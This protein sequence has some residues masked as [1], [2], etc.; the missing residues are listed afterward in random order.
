LGFS[1]PGTPLQPIPLCRCVFSTSHIHRLVIFQSSSESTQ[2]HPLGLLPSFQWRDYTWTIPPGQQ[3][4]STSAPVWLH[5]SAQAHLKSSYLFHPV[6][7]VRYSE[8]Q[9]PEGKNKKEVQ[10]LH[11]N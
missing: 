6:S 8:S 5:S 2:P 11:R 7:I 9:W 4:L 10:K 1:L 3:D